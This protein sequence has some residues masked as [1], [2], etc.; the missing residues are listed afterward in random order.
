MFD[1]SLSHP[2]PSTPSDKQG[3]NR[4]KSK[5]LPLLFLLL[6]AT[7]TGAA[8]FFYQSYQEVRR[9]LEK[10]KTSPSAAATEEN[11]KIVEEVGKLIV[12]PADET[13]TIASVVDKEKLKD[14]PFFARVE[15]GDKVLI[16][17][18]AKKVYLYRPAS[19]KIIEVGTLNVQQAGSGTQSRTANP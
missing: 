18:N 10:V 12:L 1:E 4:R 16:Y 15:N 14:Q 17:A 6:L 2:F 9:E 11:K 5:I 7:A 3:P 13:P 8:A 19:K